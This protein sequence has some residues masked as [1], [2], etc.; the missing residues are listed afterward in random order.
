M[1]QYLVKWRGLPHA[2]C[3]WEFGEDLADDAHIREYVETN[4]PPA[5]LSTW[6]RPTDPA[7]ETLPRVRPRSA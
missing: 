7:S 3:T 6:A 4:T 1:K 5:D 2:E